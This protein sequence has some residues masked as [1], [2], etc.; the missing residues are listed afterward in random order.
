MLYTGIDHHKRYAVACTQDAQ[1]RL[2]SQARLD[3]NTPEGFANYFA[4][5][6]APSAVVIEACWNWGVL[7]DL[8]EETEG[9]AEVVL[10]HPAKNRIIAEAQIKNDRIDASALATL[11]RGNFVSR[12]H[13]PAKSVRERKN[14]IRQRLWLAQMRTR[15]RNRIHTVIERHPKLPRPAVKDLFC[16]RGKAWMNFEPLM[17]TNGYRA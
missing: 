7:H 3:G 17:D 12:V 4:R 10:S 1:G 8:L 15:V 14:L 11:L 5:L 6:G 2:V 16:N 13:V 9:V